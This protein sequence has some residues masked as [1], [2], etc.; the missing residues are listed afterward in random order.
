M[1]AGIGG[2]P[3]VGSAAGAL[4]GPPLLLPVNPEPVSAA[5]R[6]EGS[7]LCAGRGRL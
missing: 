3:L 1:C 6:C 5:F 4:V 2:L 7:G